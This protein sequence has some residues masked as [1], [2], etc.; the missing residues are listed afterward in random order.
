MFAYVNSKFLYVEKH[1]KNQLNKL[2]MNI[3]EQKYALEE[4][5]LQNASSFYSTAP[6]EKAFRIMKTTCY[7]AVRRND[8]FDQMY[9]SRM[10]GQADE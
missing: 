9:S 8:T 6:D 2:Y 7:T 1:T 4:Q 10:P 3:M 5:I